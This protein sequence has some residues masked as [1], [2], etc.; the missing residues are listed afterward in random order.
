MIA[1]FKGNPQQKQHD[2]DQQLNLR[3]YIVLVGDPSTQKVYEDT[4]TETSIDMHAQKSHGNDFVP[5]LWHAHVLL[6]LVS[7]GA[8]NKNNKT[9]STNSGQSD[10]Y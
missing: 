6:P 8:P 2:G 9:Q 3:V 1:F 5:P 4:P 7:L 10:N